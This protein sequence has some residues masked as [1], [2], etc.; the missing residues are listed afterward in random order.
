MSQ[1][2]SF[3]MAST[4]GHL[5]ALEPVGLLEELLGEATANARRRILPIP[6]HGKRLGE[7]KCE[8]PTRHKWQR[9]GPWME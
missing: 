7:G 3:L 8:K 4:G 9:P 2:S 1:A 5:D 6:V